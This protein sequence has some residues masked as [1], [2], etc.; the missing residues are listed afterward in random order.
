[1]PFTSPTFYCNDVPNLAGAICYALKL[2]GALQKPPRFCM[3]STSG[4]IKTT[5]ELSCADLGRK[6]DN[7][8]PPIC[9]LWADK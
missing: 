4:G 3:G 6:A 8:P 5:S 9:S 1:M 7:A 2:A